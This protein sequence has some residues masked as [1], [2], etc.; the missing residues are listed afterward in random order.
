L[1]KS[2]GHAA[3]PIGSW[4]KKKEKKRKRWK[5]EKKWAQC[6]SVAVERTRL[7]SESFGTGKAFVTT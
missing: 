6:E 4:K 3:I 5:K 2:N 1:P 7:I